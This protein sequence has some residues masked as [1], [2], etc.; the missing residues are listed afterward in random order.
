MSAIAAVMDCFHA[1]FGT[2][3]VLEVDGCANDI[4]GSFGGK[5][6]HLPPDQALDSLILIRAGSIL[7]KLTRRQVKLDAAKSPVEPRREALV[8]VIPAARFSDELLKHILVPAA[9]V[10]AEYRAFLLGA[11]VSAGAAVTGKVTAA[12]RAWH[13][14]RSLEELADILE[15]TNKLEW[16]EPQTAA[17]RELLLKFAAKKDQ[18]RFFALAVSRLWKI[19]PEHKA[20]TAILNELSTLASVWQ[21]MALFVS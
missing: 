3:T 1:N 8:A 6:Q 16:T 14:A 20:L 15:R 2:G 7:D 11:P 5:T 18:A 13:E 4:I 10:E 9:A 19:S 21:D 12:E 17:V